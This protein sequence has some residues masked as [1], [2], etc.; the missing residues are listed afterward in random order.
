VSGRPDTDVGVSGA[1]PGGPEVVVVGSACRDIASDDPRGWRLGGSV[2][3]AALA[4][5]RLGVRTAAIIG[6]D[7][8]AFEAHELELLRRAG[9]DVLRVPLPR[10][11]VFLNVDTPGGRVQT[12]VDPGHPLPLG[13]LPGAW[14]GVR[15]WVLAPVAGE[16]DDAWADQ[17][18]ADAYVA[19]G[20]QGLLRTLRAGAL[21][22]RR[23]PAPGR[24]VRRADL[25]SLSE[26]DV[27]PG[28]SLE[29]LAACLHPGAWLVVTNGVAGGLLADVTAGGVERVAR[30]LAIAA[31]R[32]VDATGAGDTF[33]AALLA[34]VVRPTPDAA[35]SRAGGCAAGDAP[36]GEAR[37]GEARPVPNLRFAAATAS[38]AVEGLGLEA[39]PDRAAVL[40]RLAGPAGQSF[41][42]PPSSST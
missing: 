11:P 19:L 28:T 14:R 27:E 38:F 6:L 20:W 2:T 35:R 17:I 24:L 8:P 16:L 4:T 21:V 42:E 3:Y 23:A 5:A 41:P 9:A 29:D 25:V 10:G 33:F 7:P 13:A 39:L 18:P 34:S 1:G 40:R 15:A 37:P 22:T 36:P 32:E 31:E 30:Y 12:C 26:H